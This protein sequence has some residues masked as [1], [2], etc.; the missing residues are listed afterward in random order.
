MMSVAL[1]AATC[2][3]MSC[4]NGEDIGSLYGQWRLEQIVDETGEVHQPEGLYL[5]FQ[6]QVCWAKQ[7]NDKTHGY[8][9]V[10]ASCRQVGDSLLLQYTSRYG[11]ASDTSLVCKTFC[12]PSFDDCR[13]RIVR[14][15]DTHLELASASRLWRLGNY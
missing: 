15:D 4:Q 8:Q 11:Y 12:F 2:S 14:L 7:V 10:F 5:S 6:G 3:L 1:L 9:D 13:L